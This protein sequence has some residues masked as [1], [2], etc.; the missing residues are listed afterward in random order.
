MDHVN[1]DVVHHVLE[2]C[3][4]VGQPK[5]HYEWFVQSPVG[6]E[7]GFILVPFSDPD[8]IEPPSDVEFAEEFRV[9]YPGEDVGYQGERVAVFNRC[10]V[11]SP[12]ILDGSERGVLLFYEKERCCY[13]GL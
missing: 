8:V 9:L 6:D 3:R 12:V 11:Y 7:R 4:G 13:W 2:R 10:R 5:E 1:E